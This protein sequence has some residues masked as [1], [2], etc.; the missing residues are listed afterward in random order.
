MG[1]DSDSFA[2]PQRP[3]SRMQALLPDAG[4]ATYSAECGLKHVPKCE[5]DLK[6]YGRTL[7]CLSESACSCGSLHCFRRFALELA[8]L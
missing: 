7:H 2:Q 8:C 1:S 4:W 3:A 5:W 6:T